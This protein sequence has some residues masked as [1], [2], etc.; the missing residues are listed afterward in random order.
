MKWTAT[1]NKALPA[2]ALDF[3][4]IIDLLFDIFDLFDLFVDFMR[5]LGEYLSGN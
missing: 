3:D 4:D 1:G 2:K 5:N